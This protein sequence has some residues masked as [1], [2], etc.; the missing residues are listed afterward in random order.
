MQVFVVGHDWGA[1][2]AWHLCQFRPDRVRALV[3]IGIPYLHRSPSVKPTEH[4]FK[5]LDEG[6]YIHQFQVIFSCV[7]TEL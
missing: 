1:Y 3:N 4:F 5:M 2:M 6:F 7:N